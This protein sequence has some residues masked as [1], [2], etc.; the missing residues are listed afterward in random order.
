M[1]REI[2]PSELRRIACNHG[3]NTKTA[4]TT[5]GS[6]AFVLQP[7]GGDI[8]NR[9]FVVQEVDVGLRNRSRSSRINEVVSYS[10]AS[11]VKRL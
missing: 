4:T 1:P 2:V 7:N 10:E 5:K 8:H 9:L 3:E 11:E 6:L